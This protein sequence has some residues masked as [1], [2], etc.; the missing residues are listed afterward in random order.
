MKHKYFPRREDCGRCLWQRNWLAKQKGST[1]FFVVGCKAEQGAQRNRRSPN[2]IETKGKGHSR[3][4]ILRGCLFLCP[5]GKSGVRKVAADGGKRSAGSGR[6]AEG[7]GRRQSAIAVG[8]KRTL[9]VYGFTEKICYCKKSFGGREHRKKNG[10]RK[11][12]HEKIDGKR[13]AAAFG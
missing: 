1:G 9:S 3:E 8:E 4:N 6:R 7:A 13:D 11:P 12:N 5:K 10:R 2:D